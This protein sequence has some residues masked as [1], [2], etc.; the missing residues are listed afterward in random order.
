VSRIVSSKGVGSIPSLPA[1]HC[2]ADSRRVQDVADH[3]IIRFRTKRRKRHR[4]LLWPAY[5][6]PD[7]VPAVQQSLGDV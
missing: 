6:Q 1:R 2:R 5:E 3:H 7:V 4:D